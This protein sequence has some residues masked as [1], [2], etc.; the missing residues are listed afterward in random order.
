MQICESVITS[1]ADNDMLHLFNESSRLCSMP[2]YSPILSRSVI[3]SLS[4]SFTQ[5][6]SLAVNTFE[7][8]PMTSLLFV[9]QDPTLIRTQTC[10]SNQGKFESFLFLQ[11]S[12]DTADA[13]LFLSF[14]LLL[15]TTQDVNRR[16]DNSYP[17]MMIMVIYMSR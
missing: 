2:S 9:L 10:R 14:H 1:F 13:S 11:F 12:S 5:I 16:R 6:P 15:C 7:H 3:L 8:D 4:Y 17:Q